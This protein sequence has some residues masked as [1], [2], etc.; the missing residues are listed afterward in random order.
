MTQ[1]FFYHGAED[2]ISAAAALLGKAAVQK[3]RVLVFAPDA[4]LAQAIDRCLWTQPA[5]GFYPHCR[6]DSPLASDTPI[7]ITDDLAQ[8][9]LTERL[10][11]LG[12]AT[13]PEFTRF[14]SLIEVVDVSPEGR[15]SARERVQ[16]YK[17][18]G[19]EIRY[20]DLGASA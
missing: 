20:F 4:P 9:A 17:Q 19:C 5:L 8:P 15:Q 13:P 2:R 6:A 12:E 16:A 3:K 14:T 7:L 11:N 18:A 10:L 1:V